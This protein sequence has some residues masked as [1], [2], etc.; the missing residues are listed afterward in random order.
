MIVIPFVANIGGATGF[1]ICTVLLMFFGL[2]SGVA[3]GTA[4]A[5][6]AAFPSEYMAAMMFGNGLSGTGTCVLRALTLVI[7]PS[8]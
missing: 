5:T 4:F 1:Y 3:L 2:A 7:F 8:S 6:A